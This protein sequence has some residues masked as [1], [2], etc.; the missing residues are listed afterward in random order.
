[1][2]SLDATE[3]TRAERRWVW[4]GLVVVG[5]V[6]LAQVVAGTVRT[7]VSPGSTALERVQ[8]CLTERSAPF[9]AVTDDPVA[10]SAGRGALRTT[11]EGNPV[12]FALGSS[13]DD[14]RRVYDD[15]TA[16]MSSDAAN[17]LDLHGRVVFLWDAAPSQSQRDF[18][19]LCTLDVQ[20]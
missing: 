5:V 1:M 18:V 14:A 20:A 16:V 4:I 15:Y 13:E 6:A 10:Q 3:P 9:S 11:V 7:E 17:R 8:K 12:T 19:Y 2:S